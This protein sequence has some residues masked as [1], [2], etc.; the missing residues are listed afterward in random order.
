[1]VKRRWGICGSILVVV[2]C[3][4]LSFVS[5]FSVSAVTTE[6]SL[7]VYTYTAS[8]Q[9]PMSW[10]NDWTT[11]P[12][13]AEY[14]ADLIAPGSG[15]N[16]NIVTWVNYSFARGATFGIDFTWST[17][18]VGEWILLTCYS[19]DMQVEY[20]NKHVTYTCSLVS[21]SS[22][23]VNSKTQQVGNVEL[24]TDVYRLSSSNTAGSYVQTSLN[25]SIPSDVGLAMYT[26]PILGPVLTVQG[27]GGG[28]DSSDDSSSGSTTTSDDSSSLPSSGITYPVEGIEYTLTYG[29][30][31][32]FDPLGIYYLKYIPVSYGLNGYNLFSNDSSHPVSLISDFTYF[33]F[34]FPADIFFESRNFYLTWFFSPDISELFEKYGFYSISFQL[35]TPGSLNRLNSVIRG[36]DVYY[37]VMLSSSV[38]SFY[39]YTGSSGVRLDLSQYTFSGASGPKPF[40]RLNFQVSFFSSFVSYLP[41]PLF[42]FG[43]LKI[44][45]FQSERELLQE[46][47]G[48]IDNQTQVIIQNGEKIDE[49]KGSVNELKEQ[50][51]ELQGFLTE[52]DP[53]ATSRFEEAN[54]QAAADASLGNQLGNELNKVSFDPPDLVDSGQYNQDFGFLTSTVGNGIAI[55]EIPNRLFHLNPYMTSMFAIVATGVVI[56]ILITKGGG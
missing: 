7:S 8:G 12:A 9:N 14:W 3:F 25:G 44:K 13:N 30:D 38:S 10:G 43:N 56:K 48:S 28:D 47:Q 37:S 20:D 53:D 26:F 33:S 5:T 2:L 42:G 54:S 27:G 46:L 52:R 22:T 11:T 21:P 31:Y 17:D 35:L 32:W 40:D 23:L 19:Y 18:S 16:Y 36:D 4:A 55:S 1:M 39:G 29:V 51:S 50:V 49:L 15:N 6:V 45:F 41:S 34:D 24:K